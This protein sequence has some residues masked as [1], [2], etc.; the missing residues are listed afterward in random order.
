MQFDVFKSSAI[1]DF[2]FNWAGGHARYKW[3][4]RT[5]DSYISIFNEKSIFIELIMTD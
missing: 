4:I 3:Y 5:W 2:A 1:I